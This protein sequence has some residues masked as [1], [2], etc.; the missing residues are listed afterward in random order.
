[1]SRATSA[2]LLALTLASPVAAEELAP[3]DA[4]GPVARRYEAVE[5]PIAALRRLGGTPID[6]LGVLAFRG[7]QAAPIPFQVEE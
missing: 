4:C 6:Q 5:L 1:V 7:G 3:L 2:L